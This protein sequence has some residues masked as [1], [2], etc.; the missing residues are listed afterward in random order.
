MADRP[1]PLSA[2]GTWQC[3]CW[4]HLPHHTWFRSSLGVC[5]KIITNHCLLLGLSGTSLMTSIDRKERKTWYTPFPAFLFSS[6][7][8]HPS[9]SFPLLLSPPFSFIS[10]LSF[11]SLSHSPSLPLPLSDILFF[12]LS[13]PS[14]WLC[15]A[16]QEGWCAASYIASDSRSSCLRLHGGTEGTLWYRGSPALHAIPSLT[17][18][19]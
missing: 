10:L 19:K 18:V 4:H 5:F 2:Y 12:P 3:P 6:F 1:V 7:L 11:P 17:L 14:I 15:C 8:P 9:S 13:L 16:V